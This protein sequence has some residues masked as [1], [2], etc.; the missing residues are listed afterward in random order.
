MLY[1]LR[2]MPDL[3]TKIGLI[4]FDEAHQ[5]DS[6]KRGVIY[7]LLLTELKM[8]LPSTTQ[9]ILISAVIA[10]PENIAEWFNGTKLVVRGENLTAM[11]KSIGFAHWTDKKGQISYR[12]NENIDNEDFFVPRIIEEVELDKKGNERKIRTFPQK[13]D[14]SSISLY[15]GLKVVKNGA[16][17]IFCGQKRTA[18]KLSELLADALDRN[19]PLNMSINYLQ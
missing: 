7:E 10:N 1:I 5:F 6:G 16:V 2:H 11:P 8:L 9:K 3:A 13:N 12:D 14:S 19:V 18:N 17:A 15:L 4:I